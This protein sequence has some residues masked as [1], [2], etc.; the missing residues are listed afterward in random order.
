MS[1]LDS[2]DTKMSVIMDASIAIVRKGK[3][4]IFS[5]SSYQGYL[6]SGGRWIRFSPPEWY[7]EHI[8]HEQIGRNL[9][10]LI[11][12]LGSP[13]KPINKDLSVGVLASSCAELY[14]SALASLASSSFGATFHLTE[15]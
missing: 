14:R 15:K 6:I 2:E 7:I 11:K 9:F 12:N 10:E 4:C 3:S 8:T 5:F 13:L 1:D